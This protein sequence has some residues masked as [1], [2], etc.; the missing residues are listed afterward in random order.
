[1]GALLRSLILLTGLSVLWSAASA[2]IENP[3]VMLRATADKVLAELSE[4]KAELEANPSRIYPLVE[5]TVL[6]HFDFRSMSQSALGRFWRDASEAQ[7]DGLTREFRELLVRTYATALLGYTG[8]TIEYLPVQY[9]QGDT[10][11]LIPTRIA[12]SGAPPVPINYRLKL[13]D[14]TDR[15]LVYDVVIDGVSLI[16]N[17][18]SQFAAEV[19]RNGIDGLIEALANKNRSAGP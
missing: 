12:S 6:P 9:S 3:Q 16:T 18:R 11:V 14:G 5:N 2:A 19:R 7:K 10:T 8:Q 4:R 15:W 13:A 1:M 17:Y